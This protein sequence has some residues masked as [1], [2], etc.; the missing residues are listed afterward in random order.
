MNLSDR[1]TYDA[2]AALLKAVRE[3]FVLQ[4]IR[5]IREKDPG[6][7]GMKLWYMYRQTFG[8]NTSVGRDRFADIVDRFGLKVRA[9]VRKPKTTDSTHGLPFYPNLTKDFIPLRCQSVTCKRY[10]LYYHLEG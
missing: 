2:N 10:N 9:R 3:E 6:I 4:Y 5:E 8:G 7:G 1:E